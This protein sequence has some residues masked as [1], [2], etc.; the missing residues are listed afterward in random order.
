MNFEELAQLSSDELAPLVKILH[1]N[2]RLED[3]QRVLEI[4]RS[5]KEN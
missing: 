1:F 4:M 5:K 2:N 3:M